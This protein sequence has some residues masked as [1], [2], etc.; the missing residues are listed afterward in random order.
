VKDGAR[1]LAGGEYDGNVFQPTAVADVTEDMS[2]FQTECFGPVASV[3]KAKDY[4]H[5]V[6]LANNSAYGLSAGVITNDIQK[7]MDIIETLET[8]MVHINGPSVRDEPV[9]PFGG[10]KESGFGVE[11]GH[12]SMDEVTELK[13]VT[14]QT[15]QNKYPF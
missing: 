7:A 15:G 6:A 3:I 12:F 5:A 1:V 9:I 14:I 4:K 8:G 2:I 13:W 10:R 11:G